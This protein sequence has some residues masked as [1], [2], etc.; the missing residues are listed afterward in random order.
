MSKTEIYKNTVTTANSP[1]HQLTTDT[2]CDVTVSPVHD[3]VFFF[4]G[5]TVRKYRNTKSQCTSA[6]V[7]KKIDVNSAE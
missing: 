1:I 5:Y 7:L 6:R 2:F 4:F 3:E